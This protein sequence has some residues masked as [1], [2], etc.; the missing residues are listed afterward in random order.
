MK[1]GTC[2]SS[3]QAAAAPRATQKGFS[4]A[5]PITSV[6]SELDM[7]RIPNA[8]K[9]TLSLGGG[10]D[11]SSN[12]IGYACRKGRKPAGSGA[13]RWPNQDSWCVHH[14]ANQLSVYGVFDGHGEKG[15]LISDCVKKQLP[16]VAVQVA[17]AGLNAVG[18]D[19]LFKESFERMQKRIEAKTHLGCQHSGTTA[20][21]VLHDRANAR[22]TISHVGDSKV[23]LVRKKVG[24]AAHEL[25]GVEL[26]RDH[27]PELEDERARIER[28][29]GRV[30]FDGYTHRVHKKRGEGPGLN[31][32][33]SFGDVLAHNVCGVSSEP[34]T[35]VR[36]LG[37]GD[38]ALLL[39]SDGIWDVISPQQAADIVKDFGPWQAMAAAKRLADV[40]VARWLAG[41]GGTLTDDI[42]VVLVYL[43]QLPSLARGDT[44][45][46]EALS[47][48]DTSS[49]SASSSEP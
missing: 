31:M 8:E 28:A 34:E 40:A 1:M 4:D 12:G 14:R 16:Q 5:E 10:V 6:S 17:K 43:N 37:C 24:T 38:E 7:A 2:G 45:S 44:G 33:R 46:T 47:S 18:T 35:T 19:M 29:G 39:C 30:V 42:T 15:H 3:C 11:L 26:T 48:A 25:E 21:V 32:S 23:V 27:K 49:S 9:R 41:T 36:D 13:A 22:L 20:S